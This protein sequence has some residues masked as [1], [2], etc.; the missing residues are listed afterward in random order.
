M[1]RVEQSLCEAQAQQSHLQQ[2]DKMLALSM[3]VSG[4]AHEINNPNN[5]AMMSAQTLE[6]VWCHLEPVL[7]ER[8]Q[9][10]GDFRV[11]PLRYSEL[12][13]DLPGLATGIL[14]GLTRIQDTVGTLKDYV[15]ERPSCYIEA[16]DI[17]LVVKA[18]VVMCSGLVKKTTSCFSADYAAEL[19]QVRG[20]FQKLE[21]AAIN[22]IQNACQALPDLDRGVHVLTERHAAS[23]GVLI[24]VRDEGVGIAPENLSQ[25]TDPFFTTRREQGASGLGL[26]VV[27]TIV[28][29]H[30]GRIE[31]TSTVDAGTTAC[32]ILPCCEPCQEPSCDASDTMKTEVDHG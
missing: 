18:A 24:E 20:D 10:K 28:A 23:G 29:E 21:Q 12:R 8:Y 14:D 31:F 30:Q 7:D 13:E 17:N 15:Q 25:I 27:S 32:I 4:I 9:S 3:L 16:L 2:L 5:I 1:N 6:D 26:S 19:P 22:L 11:G